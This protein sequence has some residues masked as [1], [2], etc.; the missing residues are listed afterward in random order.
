MELG[1]YQNYIGG[2]WTNG[3]AKETFDVVNPATEQ[4]VATVPNATPE[5][6]RAAIDKAAA[7]QDEWADTLASERARI[8]HAAAAKMHAEAD[9]LARIMTIEEGKPLAEARGEVNYA[10]SFLD[11][12]AEEGLRIYGDTIPSSSPDKRL[13]VIKRPVGI[14]AAITPWNFPAAM[15]TRKLGPALAAGCTMIIKPSELTP[16][17]AFEMARI[18]EEVGLPKGV[19]SVVVGTDAPALAK[20][21]M[22]DFRVRK[23]SFTGSTEVGK[24]LMRQA[25][26]T[27]K[28]VSMEL[29]GHAPFLVFADADLDAAVDNA[30]SCKMRGMGETCVSANRI[31]VQRPV[32]DE[33]VRK[34]ADRMGSMRVG[35]GL[36]EGV[37]VGPLIESA[38]IEKVKRHVEDA[39][40][41]GARLVVGGKAKEGPGWF[42]TPT[43]LADVN[44]SMLITKEETFGPVAAVLP[45]DTEEEVVRY[46]NDTVYGLAAY[47]F[48]RDVGRVFRLAERLQYGIL[49]ANDGIPSTAQAPFGGVKESGIGREGSKYGI[50]E[51]LDIKYV[52]LGG[53]LS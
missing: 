12:F 1:A 35:N 2:E 32:Y 3:S 27:V 24:I 25:A 50:A 10:A 49:G 46:A 16:L 33:F 29:G 36:E 7:V 53:I 34:L 11:W 20:V 39:L 44:H 18:F 4:V 14:T 22:E 30:V 28:R 8:L 17:S 38:A 51:Y 21:I 40:A 48:T 37:T 43:V 19:L 45:F 42:Y 23:V 5:D 13:L 31:Y 26:D 52:S 47:Y 6:M 41:K 9:R 15:I